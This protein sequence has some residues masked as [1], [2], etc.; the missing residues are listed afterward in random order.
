MMVPLSNLNSTQPSNQ[1]NIWLAVKTLGIH[2]LS[3]SFS[4]NMVLRFESIV[5][6]MKVFE[7]SILL[8]QALL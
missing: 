3:L 1:H 8:P 4:T 2:L 5:A 7:S 6:G